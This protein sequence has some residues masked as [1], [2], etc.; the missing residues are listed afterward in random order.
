M[1]SLKTTK[2]VLMG[3]WI[4]CVLLWWTS[5]SDSKSTPSYNAD[6][7]V[8]SEKCQVCHKEEFRTFLETKHARLT[9]I[10]AWKDKMQGCESCHG[11]GKAHIDE[12]G[13]ITKIIAFSKKTSKEISESCLV[14]HAASEERH[15]F[16][17]GEHWR[18]DVSC[19]DCHSPHNKHVASTKSKSTTFIEQTSQLKPG[20]P[21][22]FMLRTN[23]PQLCLRCHAEM[24]AQ[25]TKPFHHRVLEGT[26]KCS[27]CHIQHGG[28]EAKQ[29]R[30]A[31]GI[32][33]AC[34]KCHSDK[35][36]PFA[37]EHAPTKIEGCMSCHTPHGASNSK[38]LIRNQ[39]NQLCMECHSNL[40][41]T[42]ISGTPNSHDQATLKYRNC[43]VCHVM[44]HGSHTSRFFFQ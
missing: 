14:C 3:I 7:Y 15:N 27:D 28:F 30:L 13:D 35:K 17:R 18:N 41:N 40:T 11:P 22:L 36:G 6:D 23:E 10:A 4:L 37:F 9:D 32:D 38:L 31:F 42:G 44:I 2:A 25:F 8:G 20:T 33:A 16:R 39:M 24:K 5:N 26:I 34:V 21:T 12:D 19:A 29:T 1:I 43:T